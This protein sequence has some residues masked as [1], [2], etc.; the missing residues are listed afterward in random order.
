MRLMFRAFLD[1]RVGRLFRPNL[2]R[3]APFVYGD[4]GDQRVS[5]LGAILLLFRPCRRRGTST[6]RSRR[7]MS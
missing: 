7:A 4:Q 2:D 3:F 1:L 5:A 6:P